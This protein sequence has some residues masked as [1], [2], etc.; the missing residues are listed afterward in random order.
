MSKVKVRFGSLA[1]AAFLASLGRVRV[2]FYVISQRI[3]IQRAVMAT[4][5]EYRILTIKKSS[6]I[7]KLSQ[8]SIFPTEFGQI[9]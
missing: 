6:E 4:R 9:G 7:G 2:A 1:V 5:V 3:F 8:S